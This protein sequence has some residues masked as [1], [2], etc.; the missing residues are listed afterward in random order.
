MP[1]VAMYAHPIGTFRSSGGKTRKWVT[2]ITMLAAATSVDD[3]DG[4]AG[5]RQVASTNTSRT[6]PRVMRVVPA[7]FGRRSRG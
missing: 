3:P 1:M 5:Q 7:R 2:K 4:E 6:S